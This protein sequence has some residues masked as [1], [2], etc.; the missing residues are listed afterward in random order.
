MAPDP[1]EQERSGVTVELAV[2]EAR[3]DEERAPIP[4]EQ[5]REHL[6]GL[7]PER[8]VSDWGR[9]ER[10]EG[11]VDRTLYEFL[12]HYWFRVEVQGIEN[13]PREGGALL[14]ANRAGALPADSLMVARAIKQEHPHGRLLHVATEHQLSGVPALG[15]LVTKLGGV[16]AHPANVHRL[17]FDEHQLVLLFPEGPAG[18]RK[19]IRERYRLRGFGDGAFVESAMRARAP[20]VPVAVL[21]GEEALPIIARIG[22][23]GPLTARARVPIFSALPLPA[24]FKI[25]FLEPVATDS[26]GSA[27]WRDRALVQAVSGDIRALIQENLLEMVAHRRSAWLS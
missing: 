27:P 26:L 18:A 7:E 13:V 1:P 21:G 22:L 3:L 25:R 6:P 19:S 2:S 5:L 15:T 9:S 4:R 14:A 11:L 10:L 17:L 8:R 24:K 23:M 20:I 12:Y 16:L